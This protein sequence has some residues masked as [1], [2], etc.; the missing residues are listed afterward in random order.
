MFRIQKICKNLLFVS[1]DL[2]RNS[3][4]N[5]VVT[6]FINQYDRIKSFLYS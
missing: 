6:F 4:L 1:N 2:K 5:T 3:C